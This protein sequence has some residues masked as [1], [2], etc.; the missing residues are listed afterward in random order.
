MW[1]SRLRALR[2][3]VCLGRVVAV[4]LWLG[5]W[6][7]T[8][9]RLR[10]QALGLGAALSAP[11]H[12]CPSL[13]FALTP[14]PPLVPAPHPLPQTAASMRT[15][16]ASGLLVRAR[17]LTAAPQTRPQRFNVGCWHA[18]DV[19]ITVKGTRAPMK[20]W[21]LGVAWSG[22]LFAGQDQSGGLCNCTAIGPLSPFV[23]PLPPCLPLPPRPTPISALKSRSCAAATALAWKLPLGSSTL[24]SSAW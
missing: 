7:G 4:T 13:T 15:L 9:R 23:N 1:R 16:A 18:A 14:P 3:C 2:R 20:V 5:V 24:V 10:S 11:W 21:A 8:C 22:L 12:L 19:P 6:D 17:Q